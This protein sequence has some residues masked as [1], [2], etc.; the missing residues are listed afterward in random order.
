[1]MDTLSASDGL[2]RCP[3][4]SQEQVILYQGPRCAVKWVEALLTEVGV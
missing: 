2:D 3:Q 4:G 1:M